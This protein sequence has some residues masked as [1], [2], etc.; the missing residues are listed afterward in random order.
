MVSHDGGPRQIQAAGRRDAVQAGD[1]Q[2]DAR[3]LGAAGHGGPSH[4]EV[5]LLHDGG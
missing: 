3:L 1:V 4:D 5:L 2:H